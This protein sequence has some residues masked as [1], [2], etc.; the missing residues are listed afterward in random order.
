MAV[1][2]VIKETLWWSALRNLGLH[3]YFSV[4]NEQA[5]ARGGNALLTLRQT[6]AG[7]V[8]ALRVACGR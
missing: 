2:V 4:D 8:V 5:T 1:L 6:T 3:L 7:E